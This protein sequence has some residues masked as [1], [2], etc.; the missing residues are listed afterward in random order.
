M[1]RPQ[2]RDRDQSHHPDR[3]GMNKRTPF[4][5][6]VFLFEKRSFATTGSGQTRRG[7]AERL[8]PSAGQ[9]GF[10]YFQDPP[11]SV[12]FVFVG[13]TGVAPDRHQTETKCTNSA[14]NAVSPSPQTLVEVRKRPFLRCHLIDTTC[15]CPASCLLMHAPGALL[16]LLKTITLPRQARD[17]H[18]GKS[19]QKR[20][21]RVLIGGDSSGGREALSHDRYAGQV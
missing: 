11:R 15:S 17:K 8:A 6:T 9:E 12:N 1:D 4:V 7:K 10:S 20:E 16:I 21:M 19:T 2:L 5:Y 3:C 14:T 13:T 18:K